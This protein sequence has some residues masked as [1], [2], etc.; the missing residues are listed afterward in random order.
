[1]SS[2]WILMTMPTG[3]RNGRKD[4]TTHKRIARVS[5]DSQ[6]SALNILTRDISF[7]CARKY[8]SGDDNFQLST[9]GKGWENFITMYCRNYVCNKL[10]KIPYTYYDYRTWEKKATE[11]IKY[12]NNFE[13]ENFIKCEYRKRNFSVETPVIYS[14]IS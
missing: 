2:N 10:G 12:L 14:E 7:H 4:C 9:R 6:F 1:M 5:G 13:L 8:I 3:I 11:E